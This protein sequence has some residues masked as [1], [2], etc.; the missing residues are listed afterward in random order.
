MGLKLA[1]HVSSA[2]EDVLELRGLLVKKSVLLFMASLTN[3][4]YARIVK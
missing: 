1:L 3:R 4:G 2:T